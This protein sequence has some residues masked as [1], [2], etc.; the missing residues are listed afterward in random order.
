[1]AMTFVGN[2]ILLTKESIFKEIKKVCTIIIEHIS[3]FLQRDKPNCANS[4]K[5]KNKTK[6]LASEMSYLW[7]SFF[8]SYTEEK[9]V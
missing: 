8:F 3:V 6:S 4:H 5:L 1:M 9:H 7:K 2:L